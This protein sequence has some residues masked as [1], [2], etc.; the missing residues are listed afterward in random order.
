MAI[1][2]NM[3]QFDQCFYGVLAIVNLVVGSNG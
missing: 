3:S 2:F 1:W